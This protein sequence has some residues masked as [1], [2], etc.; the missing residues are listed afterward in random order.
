MPTEP[1]VVELN[2]QKIAKHSLII[3]AVSAVLLLLYYFLS[4]PIITLGFGAII[5]GFTKISLLYIVLIILHEASHLIGFVIFGGASWRSLKYGVNLKLGVAYA[6]TS[7][8]LTNRAM[9][10]ALLLPFWTTGILP[11]LLGMYWQDF[12]LL[13]VS[14]LLIGGAAGDFAMYKELRSF[15]NDALVKDDPELPKLYIYPNS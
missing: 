11:A 1:I 7:A 12:S 3:T 5:W 15:P 2:I 10:K 8:D 13:L 14:A 4:D 6:T 9:K